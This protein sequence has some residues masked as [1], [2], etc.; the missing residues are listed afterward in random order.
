MERK[1]F[2]KSFKMEAVRQM[3]KGNRSPSD[4]ARELGIRRNQLYKWQ[5][6]LKL[7]GDKAFPGGGRRG[8]EQLTDVEALQRRVAA[9]EEE[10][11]ILKKAEA[12]FTDHRE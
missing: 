11:A 4:I 6:Q 9:L 2:T 1:K 8:T 3:E 7:R 5:R 10:N 12:Y